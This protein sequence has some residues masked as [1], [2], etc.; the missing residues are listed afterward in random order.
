MRIHELNCGTL[1][2]RGGRLLGSALRTLA[3]RCLL[4]E[5]GDRLLLADTGI[6]ETDLLDPRGRLGLTF[7]A[8]VRPA[9]DP[10]ETALRQLR[11][12]GLRPED[13]SDIL[14]SHLDVDHAGGLRDFPRARV[15]LSDRELQGAELHP[16][17]AE[18][19]RYHRRQWA[20]GA[21][22]ERYGAEGEPWRGFER[23]Q[24]LRGLG[25]DV[26][27]VPLPG[28]TRGHCGFALRQERGWL[29]YAGDAILHRDELS[30][31]RGQEPMGLRLYHRQMALLHEA[32]LGSLRALR[33]CQQEHSDQVRIVCSHEAAERPAV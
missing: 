5:M 17:G 24:P 27:L 10:A 3:C 23:V 6:G 33:R 28:H 21:R 18:R 20:H 16:S 11:G 2:P 1:R 30:A 19:R 15:H 22:W 32:R 13:V 25:A 29:L 8:A 7:L 4:V 31:W 9:L 12:L 26:L 14:I